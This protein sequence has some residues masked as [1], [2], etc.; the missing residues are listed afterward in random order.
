[1]RLR[2]VLAVLLTAAVGT[3]SGCASLPDLEGMQSHREFAQEDSRFAVIDGIE[4]HYKEYGGGEE[5][6]V[7]LHG[8]LSNLHTWDYVG[9]ELQDSYKVYVYDRLAFGITERP[10]TDRDGKSFTRDMNPYASDR[11][12]QRLVQLLDYWDVESAVLVGN[13]AG[14]NLAV[15][16]ALAY[17]ERVSALVLTAPAVYRSGPPGIAR[18]L[19]RTGLF[20]RFALRY[21]RS[22]Q[23][24]DDSIFESSWHYPEL[25]PDELKAWYRQPL[26]VENW[27][28]ALWEY[29]R[30]NRDPGIVKR[31][32]ELELPIL[33]IH[34]SEDQV[35]SVDQSRRLVQ[36]IPHAR[37][38]IFE[39]T[40]HA[41]QEE[42][43]AETAKL[44]REF[45]QE[46]RSAE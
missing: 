7:M 43:P 8:F 28:R 15:Q 29:T 5:A 30:M 11:V 32:G 45:L 14:A 10:V 2:Y 38:I 20:N 26:G 21:I 22:F 25:M 37:L 18:L 6:L 13:S 44:M 42:R 23:D 27:D 36:D 3:M 31:L 24:Q 39:E 12:L 4:I 17:P 34:G 33:I 41:P 46:L 1:M 16:A 40:G 19:I 35:V 9:E